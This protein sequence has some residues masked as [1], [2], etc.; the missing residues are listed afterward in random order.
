MGLI[1]PI[2]GANVDPGITHV[3][4]KS[5]R[6]ARRVAIQL[7]F[8]QQGEDKISFFNT[9]NYSKTGLRVQCRLALEP[10]QAIVAL[11]NKSSLPHGYCRVVWTTGHEAG[12][13]FVN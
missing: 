4:R 13:E 3:N 12:L 6:T 8:K 1:D 7:A 2:N 10:G 9:V 5:P 11:P